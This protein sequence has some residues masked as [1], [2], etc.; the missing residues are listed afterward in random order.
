MFS[1][2]KS[3]FLHSALERIMGSLSIRYSLPIIIVTPVILGV[4]ASCWFS[5][6]ASKQEIETIVEQVSE[7]S[8]KII[9]LQIH[10]Y[11]E[12]PQILM[13]SQLAATQSSDLKIDNFSY[14]QRSFWHQLQQQSILFNIYFGNESGEF[15]SVENRNS[16]VILKIRDESTGANKRNFYQ[17]DSQGNRAKLIKSAPY[18]PRL[19]PWYQVAKKAEKVAWTPIYKSADTD[20]II[21]SLALPILEPKTGKFQGA[22]STDITLQKLSD[23][24]RNLSISATGKAFILE[25]SGN[26]VATSSQEQP[27][28]TV[29]GK[30]ERLNVIQSQEPIIQ[31]T[32][33]YLSDKFK[34]LEAIESKQQFSFTFRGDSHFVEVTPIQDPQGLNW[35]L[36]VVIPK[37]D[38]T[39]HIYAYTRFT[40]I[41]G[42]VI[43]GGAVI[44]GLLMVRWINQPI[45]DLYKAAK[46]I[47]SE[48]FDAS[49]LETVASRRDEFG[50]LG[51][52]FLAMAQ[53]IYSREH[54]LKKM[55]NQLQNQTTKIQSYRGLEI[56]QNQVYYLEELLKEAEKIRT[57][58][59]NFPESPVVENQPK[60]LEGNAPGEKQKIIGKG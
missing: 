40:I 9:E 52:V 17:L 35:L 25:R 8:T 23:F 3:S 56:S 42:I 36:V 19:R 59:E 24:L 20:A 34:S 7:K 2:K 50:E 21:I 14:L 46:A 39:K 29:A 32:G 49:S 11:L 53:V 4:T 10:N 31:A 38:F 47:E 60:T 58:L 30:Q 43:A 44:L 57:K 18:D 28:K 48:K 16:Q 45:Q 55:L 13:R 54:N 37:A 6:V 41:L 1:K 12:K 26:L 5:F 27:F 51:K 22:L 15:L 33:Q